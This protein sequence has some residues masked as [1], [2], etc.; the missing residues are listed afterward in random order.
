MEAIMP[1]TKNVAKATTKETAIVT[2]EEVTK[3]TNTPADE[4]SEPSVQVLKS[5]EI[6]N[7]PLTVYGTMEEPLFLAKDVAEMI[8]YAKTGAGA[9]NVS[10]MLQTVDEDEKLLRKI[11]V[12]AQNAKK[13][14]EESVSTMLVSGQ[15]REVWMLT[16]HGLYEVL[17]QSRKPIAKEFKRAVKDLLKDIRLEKVQAVKGLE[18][19]MGEL[20][21]KT[22]DLVQ[23]EHTYLSAVYGTPEVKEFAQFDEKRQKDLLNNNKELNE[24]CRKEYNLRVNTENYNAQLREENESLKCQVQYLKTDIE[25]VSNRSKANYAE[26]QTL[27]DYIRNNGIERAKNLVIKLRPS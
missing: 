1:K 7:F 17:M 27:Y 25:L 5:T 3:T 14:K 2:A 24:Y 23:V 8:D 11:F 21:L 19:Y 16:E 26:L 13:D 22:A 4:S 9:Y 6:L 20:L 15:S 10:V 18:D 12:P